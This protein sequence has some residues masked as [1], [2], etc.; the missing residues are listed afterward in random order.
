MRT[1]S[2]IDFPSEGKTYGSYKSNTPGQAASKAFSALVKKL[3]YDKDDKEKFIIF[4]I[5]D[6]DGGK[7][8]EYV[9]TKI[10]LHKPIHVGNRIYNYRNIVVSN[11]DNYFD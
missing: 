4:T 5:K 11:K 6:Q 3:T 7:N 8:Y 9:G 2:I 10:K 1:F